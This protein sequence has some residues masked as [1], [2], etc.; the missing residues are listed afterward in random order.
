MIVTADK[1]FDMISFIKGFSELV[2]DLETTGLNPYKEDRLCGIAIYC[3]SQSFYFPFRHGEGVNLP[4]SY[5]RHFDDVFVGKKLVGWNTKFDLSFLLADNIP[6]SDDIEDVMLCAHLLNENESNFRLKDLGRKYIDPNA[7]DEQL[8]LV[9]ELSSRGLKK[10]QMWRLPPELVYEYAEMDVILT[11]KLKSFYYPHLVKHSLSN[12]WSEYNY[13]LLVILAMEKRGIKLNVELIHEYIKRN[14]D[15]KEEILS[16]I[17]TLL[18]YTINPNS[19]KQVSALFGIQSTDV[20]TLE[21]IDDPIARLIVEFRRCTKANSSYYKALLDNMDSEGVIHPNFNIIGT[22][23][24]RLSCNTPNLQAIPRKSDDPNDPRNYIKEVFKAR[25]G[26]VLVQ[27]DYK[28]AEVYIGA[29]YAKAKNLNQMIA[30]GKDIHGETASSLGIPRFAAKRLNFSLQ[31]G[32]GAYS[33]SK[34]LGVTPS[35]A[36]NY[37]NLYNTVHP[38]ISEL[39]DHMDL[40]ARTQGYIT[41]FTGRRRLYDGKKS[42]YHKASS[43][44]IQG[45]VAEIMRIASTK[46]YKF[47]LDKGAYQLLHVH[48]S[49]ILEIPEDRVQ[50][51]VNNI[52]GI[53]TDFYDDNG[54]PLFTNILKVDV[55]YGRDWYNMKGLQNV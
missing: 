36:Q 39:Y 18:G 10:G 12:L 23:T 13:Y 8:E 5:I 22:V 25:K 42:P 49:I 27:L 16:E 47:L 52:I 26:Y 24:G 53:M 41:Q 40:V 7:K 2:F 37:I 55:E 44:L 3:G 48:D 33:L 9:E 28:Q 54:N 15:R 50:N 1:F 35:V 45:T 43:N 30:E 14:D 32:I 4:L 34:D 19:P 11:H 29:H 21:G 51:L 31:Y 38:E 46:I 20:E 6:I 17:K